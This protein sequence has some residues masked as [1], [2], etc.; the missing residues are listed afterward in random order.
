LVEQ[1][2][3]QVL[4]LDREWSEVEG[5]ESGAVRS[6]VGPENLAYVIYT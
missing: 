5:E 3:L 4:S 1:E 6:G 2:G